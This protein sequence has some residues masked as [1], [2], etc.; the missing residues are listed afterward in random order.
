[1]MKSNCKHW[2]RLPFVI[3]VVAGVI[4]SGA[5]ALDLASAGRTNPRIAPIQSRP[6]G[7]T[8][9]AWA[10][11]WW[12]WALGMP[13]SVNAILDETGEFCAEGQTGH[14]WFLGGTFG[15][16]P[17]ERECTVPSGTAL[18]FP[19]VNTGYGAFLDDPPEQRT[20]EFLRAQIACEEPTEL[21]AVID[22]VEVEDP[23]QYFEQSPLFDVQLPEDNI[24]G[25]TPED[26][27]ELLL[28]PTV[29]QGY[30]LFLAPLPPGE[31][32]IEWRAVWDDPEP[33]PIC[34]TTQ[35]ITYYLT[36]SPG[37]N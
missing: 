5:I 2:R 26:I 18:F 36:V 9:G 4:M 25:A 31:H 21:F 22:G 37:H 3:A 10:A 1:M 34:E 6:H 33:D 15:F 27:P 28:S 17:V 30:Y 13:P 11:E 16:S 35:D 8:Y 14:V 32:V 23:F 29:D 24:F 20:E 19:L 7:K 12:Q